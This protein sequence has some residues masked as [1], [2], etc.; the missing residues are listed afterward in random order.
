MTHPRLILLFLLSLSLPAF[1][2]QQ[3]AVEALRKAVAFYRAQVGYRGAYLWTYSADLTR[4][5]GEGKA[6]RTSGWTQPPGT[7]FV[8]EAY[9]KAWRL[10]GE[11]ACREAAIECA[12]ALV[13]SQLKS[14]G[15]SSHF[16]LGP[17]GARRYA[18]RRDGDRAGNRNLTTFDDF[19]SQ[20]ALLLL[21]HVDEELGFEDAE[22]HEAVEY[23]LD[24]ML[25]AQYP[26][27]AW[28]QQYAE[29]PDPARFP[30]KKAAYPE[31]WSRRYEGKRY[32]DYYTLN[33]NNMSGIIDMLIEAWRIYGRDDCR[34]AALKTGDFFILAQ[35]PEPQP[36][37]AQQYDHDM[38]P[39]WA[40]KFEPPAITGGESQ[41]VMQSLID[42]YRQ[43]GQARF[44]EPIPRALAY[45]R[46]SLLP[47]GR[48][49][50]FYE[51]RTNR[52]LYFTRDYQLTYRDDDLP[53]HYSFK[54]GSKLDAIERAWRKARQLK[55][56]Q[57]KV[58]HRELKP[59]RLTRSVIERGTQALKSL[60]PRGA[61]VEA[62]RLRY[63]GSDD[64]TRRIISMR[65]F[66]R[67]L[68]DLAA[69]A[70]ARP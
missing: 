65:S 41:A 16:D 29:P 33:D 39:A 17:E 32:L 69:L 4:R 45:Y 56:G 20:S 13:L 22:I 70:G 66:A 37:W 21:M 67:R 9:L 42:L 61:W 24:H 30:V 64:D 47:D 7:P 53:T 50:R 62:G 2:Q 34:A 3:A 58:D 57:F 43:T 25:A 23:A 12:R 48:L 10:S 28:P 5:E 52:P 51:L 14:G 1:G 49:A 31:Q 63:H 36:G 68:E 55:P 59:V 11:P 38:H 26:N 6:S 54:V 19:K 15:W 27:G 46:R 8:G 60:D 40:R 18:Y 35:M 44:L